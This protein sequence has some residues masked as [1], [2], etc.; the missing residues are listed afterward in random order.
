[1]VD[2]IPSILV[3]SPKEFEKELRAVEN[4]VSQVQIDVADGI[5]VP[6]TTWADPTVIAK[7]LATPAEL[8]L[9]VADPLMEIRR[10]Q[11]MKHITRILVHIETEPEVA[12]IADVCKKQGWSLSLVLNPETPIDAIAPFVSLVQGVMFMGVHPGRQ[13]QKFIPE[14][15]TK[16]TTCKREFPQLF[17]ELDGGVNEDTL[18]QIIASGIDAVCPGSAIFVNERAP[19]E[20]VE[21]M[22]QMLARGQI[23][24]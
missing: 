13:G 5:F 10:W 18:P 19:A 14:V 16:I 6:K 3:E 4:V 22:K 23:G 2:I 9:M 7:L 8:H 15:L 17:I 20:N 11:K 21:R 1:M 12:R 24:I